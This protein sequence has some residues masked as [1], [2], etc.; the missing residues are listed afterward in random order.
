ME[1]SP[2]ALGRCFVSFLLLVLGTPVLAQPSSPVPAEVEDALAAIAPQAIRAHMRF[3]ADDLLEGRR[4]ATRGYDLAAKYVAASLEALGLEPAGAGGGYFQPVPLLRMA[5][6][7]SDCSLAVLRNGRRTELLIGEDYLVSPMFEEEATVTAPVVYVGF[8]VIAPELGYDDYAGVDVRGKIV[9][10]LVG[11]PPTFPHDQGAYYSDA[12]VQIRNA[13][14]RGAVGVLGIWTSELETTVTAW[15]SIRRES[16]RPRLAWLD[17]EG[18][19]QDRPAGMRALG[20]LRWKAAQDLFA[21]APHRLEEALAAAGEGRPLSF[22]LPVQISLRSVSRHERTASSNV[23]AVLRGSD[24]RLREEYVVLS[25]HLD[26]VGM[27]EPVAGD[28]IFN[29]AY[30]NASGVAIVLEVARA[31]ARLPVPPRRSV[32][33]LFFTAEE[34]GLQ[35]SDFFARFPT[36]PIDRIVANV[37]LDMFLML[38]PLRDVIA[39]GAEH[40]SLGAVVEQA[41]RHLG[42]ALSPDPFPEQVL[43]IRSDQYSFIQRGIP[44]LFLLGGFQTGDPALDGKALWGKW[45]QETYHKPGDDMSQAIDF[46]AGAQCA[47]LTFLISHRIAQ[48]ENVPSWN[49]GDFFATTFRRGTHP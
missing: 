28:S 14:D 49:P 23:A 48:E 11:A 4:A 18:R 25:A 36:V 33:F 39:F 3:L 40:S 38:Y 13:L 20:L 10:S 27:G 16:R 32:L 26:H 19:P 6:V 43:F 30:D 46:E 22:D 45:F 5:S 24:P 12:K 42:I 21:G 7:E 9:L 29:G 1:R 47:R 34:S 2:G 17:E 35:G 15:E 8:G 31:L 41:A 37:N 44:A